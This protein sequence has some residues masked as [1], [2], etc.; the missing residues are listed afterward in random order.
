MDRT[1]AEQI[2]E[3]ERR[4]NEEY[5]KKAVVSYPP[6]WVTIA[7]SSRCTN[8]CVFCSYHSRDARQGKS[9]VYNLPYT[10]P[11]QRFKQQI[12]FFHAGHVPHVHI[13]STGEPFLH[14]DIMPMIDY[15]IDKY[16]NASFQSNFNKKV[17]ERGGFLN[18]IIERKSNISYVVTDIHA[19][20][21]SSYESIKQGSSL[22]DLIETLKVLSQ[23]HIR[24]I[25]SCIISKNNYKSLPKII[26][27]LAINRIKLQLNVVNLFPHMFNDFTSLDN[28]YKTADKEI[29]SCLHHLRQLGDKFGIPVNIPKPHDDPS[30]RCDVF[31]QKVQVWP[32]AGVDQNRYDENLI[33]H[34]CNAVVLGNINTL[35]YVSDYATVMDFWNNEHLVRYRRKIL[36]GEYPDPYCWSCCNGV[37]LRP[38]G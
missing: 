31:W 25:G 7:I 27:L 4:Y 36:A 38:A 9:N 14:K 23:H 29:S 26:E 6:R 21:A 20:D 12:D 18:K 17:I 28:V 37:N 34:A 1:W 32:V 35:G 11:L 16:G 19:G 15:V 10:M 8:H 3:D 2:R 13:C 24:L 33:P 22:T 30:G 5:M